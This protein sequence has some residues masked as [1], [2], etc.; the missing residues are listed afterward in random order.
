MSQVKSL[1]EIDAEAAAAAAGPRLEMRHITKNFGGVRALRDVSVLSNYGEVH[2]ICGENGAGKSTLMKILAG[3]ITD[4]DGEIVLEGRPV[5]FSGPREAED[6]GIR[7]IYQELNLVPQLTVANNIFLGREKTRGG[8]LGWLD[9][10][11]MEAQTRR[12]FDRLGA[13]IAPR[14]KVGDLRI[15]DQQMVEIAKALA[16]DAAIV[17]MDEPTSALSDSEVAR[18]FRVIDDLRRAGTT[19]LYISHKM[20]EVFTLSDRVTVLRDG[21][22]VASAER[23]ATTPDQVVRWM[24]GREIAALNY[25]PHAIQSRTTLAVEDLSMPSP[26]G[27]GLPSLGGI[28]FSV[29]AG[30]V[31]GVAGLLGAGAHRTPRGDLWRQ[32]VA[33]GGDPPLR[34]PADPLST[35]RRGDPGR[36]RHGHRGPQDPRPLRP[37]DRRR[38]HHAPPPPRADLRRPAPD[39]PPRRAAAAHPSIGRSGSWPSR[40]PAAMRP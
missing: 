37:D 26:P 4:Y 18:L 5:R 28:T 27:S 2:S 20:N 21:Q 32:P 31:L 8:R 34:G 12:L 15:G 17:I 25:Q 1:F 36:D 40:R 22:F 35:P 10:R 7:I 19:V 6:A 39:R 24:V 29:R 33:A 30:E 11:A 23:N 14:A 13:A 9:D 38:E 16:F 3:A